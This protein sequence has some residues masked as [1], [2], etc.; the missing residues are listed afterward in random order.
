MKWI[1][2]SLLAFSMTAA[3]SQTENCL[4]FDGVDD[5]VFIGDLADMG[6]SDF[7]IEA[8]IYISGT[9]A[10]MGQKVISKG[11]SSV[12]TPANA[13]YCL[14][15]LKTGSEELEFFVVNSDGTNTKVL[16]NGIQ[17]NEW[18]HIAGVRRADKAYLY[19]NGVLVGEETCSSVYN[20][21]T[22]LPLTIGYLDK[23][24]LSTD[25]EF[26][27][28]K[29]DEVR[30]WNTARV[31]ADI[32]AYK[33]C[34]MDPNTV[35]LVA[36]YNL[37]ESS[38]TVAIDS[39]SNNYDGTFESNPTW[40][41]STVATICVSD[42]S[43]FEKIENLTIFPN[44]VKT[45]INIDEIL[46]ELPYFLTDMSGKLVL[47]GKIAESK[48]DVEDIPNGTYIL[49]INDGEEAYRVKLIKE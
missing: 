27:Q 4:E 30:I 45:T 49:Q 38:G 10:G 6:T 3:F 16:Y 19:L 31:E 18:M 2:T 5:G 20:V 40:V 9:G 14:R 37:N 29:I 21:D 11:I 42:L 44:P 8:W 28:G 26:F 46:N 23:I 7:T 33:D 48:I 15:V 25:N 22:N 32:L 41:T 43:K 12:G 13:G 47:N 1:I 24:D 34:A 36:L 17:Q 35:G 39:T